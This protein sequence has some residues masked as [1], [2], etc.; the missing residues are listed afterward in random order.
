MKNVG[1][2]K[3]VNVKVCNILVSVIKILLKI[4]LCQ[5]SQVR[6][7]DIWNLEILIIDKMKDYK[8][9][10]DLGVKVNIDN[11]FIEQCKEVYGVLE[12][13]CGLFFIFLIDFGWMDVVK[14]E[15]Y[16]MLDVFFRELYR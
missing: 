14:Y 6:V 3:R 11:F 2:N 7:M 8:L 16:L 9:L 12:K 4:N 5:V 1:R 15:I 13:W 10:I